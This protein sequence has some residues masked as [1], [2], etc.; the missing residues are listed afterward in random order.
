[1]I[2]EDNNSPLKQRLNDKR[3]KVIEQDFDNSELREYFGQGEYGML[4]T[5]NT[6]NIMY[7][8]PE[9]SM[10]SDEYQF[11]NR[12]EILVK[13][14]ESAEDNHSLMHQCEVERDIIE[15]EALTSKNWT[16]LLKFFQK[17]NVYYN[18]KV[19]LLMQQIKTQTKELD[20]K[21]FSHEAEENL[22]KLQFYL[23]QI[24]KLNDDIDKK[25]EVIMMKDKKIKASEEQQD[26]QIKELED[27]H[28]DLIIK[29]SKMETS[30]NF[31]CNDEQKFQDRVNKIEMNDLIELESL[32]LNRLC[33]T[34]KNKN[35]VFFLV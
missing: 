19:V 10:M 7:D 4:N 23:H 11:S 32:I 3:K 21:R 35:E 26:K 24:N 22:P 12:I 18:E 2:E 25:N 16:G 29:M 5:R 17:V 8:D 34:T 27:K 9:P 28:S 14:I 20:S 33:L 31:I 6:S 15:S 30:I 1:M 13:E